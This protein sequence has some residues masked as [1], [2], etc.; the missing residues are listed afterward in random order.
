VKVDDLQ[1]M[2]NH[3]AENVQTGMSELAKKQGTNGMPA[4]PDTGTA[5]SDVPAPQPDATA[6]KALQDQDQQASQAEA[7]ARVEAAG[8]NGNTQ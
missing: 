4:A 8:S 7:Q 1:E 2:Y 5:P 6:A 3:F